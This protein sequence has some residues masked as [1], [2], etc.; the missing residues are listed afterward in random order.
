MSRAWPR[1]GPVA[2]DATSRL[3]PGRYADTVEPALGRLTDDEDDLR[4]LIELASA[5]NTRLQAQEERHPAGLGRADVVF[6]TPYSKFVNAAFTNPGQGARFHGRRRG[7]WYCALAVETAIAEVGFHRSV[8]L[9]ETGVREEDASYRQFLA[10]VHAQ[11]FAHLDD[12]S[13]RSAA[14]LDPDSY[15]AGQDLADRLLARGAGGVLYP[16]VRH[17]GGTNLA[18]LQPAIVANV[19]PGA[20]YRLTIR[21]GVVA[22]VRVAGR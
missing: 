19:R 1:M 13:R 14:C 5:T 11:D 9:A 17:P 10:D 7:A 2:H 6:G 15:V 16:A 4:N 20:A 8:H 22:R 18:V 21:D 3:I 12:G